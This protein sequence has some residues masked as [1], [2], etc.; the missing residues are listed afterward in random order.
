M[1]MVPSEGVAPSLSFEI[2]I[3]SLLRLLF[4]HEGKVVPMEGIAPSRFLVTDF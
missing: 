4:R 1:P 3:L 2:Q